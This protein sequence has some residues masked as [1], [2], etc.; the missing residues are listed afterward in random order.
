[1]A[2]LR[3]LDKIG[4]IVDFSKSFLP[5]STYTFTVRPISSG[6][7][8]LSGIS[9][10][11]GKVISG[12]NSAL[13]AF[14]LGNAI[15]LRGTAVPFQ[16]M[17]YGYNTILKKTG[18]PGNPIPSAQIMVTNKE[19]LMIQGVSKD[20][21][22][23]GI[24]AVS[25]MEAFNSL[26]ASKSPVAIEWGPVSKE[27]ILFSME[28][29]VHRQDHIEFDIT[30]EVLSDAGDGAFNFDFKSPFRSVAGLIGVAKKSFDATLGVFN[31]LPAGIGQS[32]VNKIGTPMNRAIL[33][34]SRAF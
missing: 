11:L 22:L 9:G 23:G 32:V 6:G 34:A 26:W 27:A 20:A 29:S 10:R 13:G 28:F 2:L 18:Y 4:S 7:G 25:L 14:G 5:G 8:A 16:P 12:V 15:T 1:M 3:R 24:S 17:Q 19:P 21:Q 33:S 31:S 30:F